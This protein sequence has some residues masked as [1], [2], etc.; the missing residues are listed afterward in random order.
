MKT[1]QRVQGMIAFF[2]MVMG[3][4]GCGHS[5]I[6][7]EA[8][9]QSDQ[10]IMSS[11]F[12][13]AGDFPADVVIPDIEG[14]KSTAFVV[15]TSLP[16]GVIAIDIDADPMKLS[17]KFA[18]FILPDGAGI[19]SRLL[20]SAI[21][22]AFIL[23]SNSIISFNPISGGIYESENILASVNIGS[24][25][26]N[27]DGSEAP[28]TVTPSYPGGIA[29]VGDTLFASTANYTRT[30]TPAVAAPGTVLVFS[31]ENDH[32]LSPNGHILTSHFNPTGLSVRD[33]EDLVITNSGV[34][35]IVDAKGVPKTPSAI[36]IVD[37][38][39]L[40]IKSTIELG[41]VGASFHDVEIT[42]D[43]SRGFIGSSVYGHVYEIDFINTQLLRGFDN[44]IAVNDGSDY[45]SDVVLSVDNALLFAASFE[46]STV[47]PLDL[48]VVP[49]SKGDG[50]VVG[51][52]AGVTETNP[53]GANTGAGPV[54]VRPG[55][56][57]VNYEGEDLF[58]LTGYPGTLVAIQSNAP[59]SSNIS[60]PD[61]SVGDE[62]SASTSQ[63]GQGSAPS[64]VQAPTPPQGSS[65]TSCQGFA[66]AVYSVSYGL[67]AGFGQ[68]SFPNIVLGAPKG[69]GAM[70][71]ST[72]VL[73]LGKNGEIVIDLGNCHV[74][75]GPGTDF[76][77][78]ENPF[79]IGG[80]PSAPYAELGAVAVS[81]NGTSFVEF[82]CNS[83]FYPYNGCAGWHPVY[84]NPGNGISPF[85]IN[86]AGGDAFDLANIGVEDARYIRIRDLKGTS[87]GTAAGFDLDAVAVVNGEIS[88]P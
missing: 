72:D 42:F 79:Y 14:M 76:I 52:P 55:T 2:V 28:D 59:A 18:G 29:R 19:P 49:P 24:G 58:I 60:S 85:D 63:Q 53:S 61:T 44:P 68:G 5:M 39:S 20:V 32:L 75:D 26:K 23:T 66:Q 56:R 11:S 22:Q 9:L 50:F 15:S 65:S 37:P 82:S 48:S 38:K 80:N 47:Y 16:A 7:A 70:G 27:S 1:L 33:K 36:D 73:S 21:D 54:A 87:G 78:F 84:S 62:T 25:Y 69:A 13:L 51:Y 6:S 74:V 30:Q 41:M 34:V 81:R 40:T 45:V 4:V 88:N 17:T 10:S 46:D 83:S 64:Q 43:G 86:T 31:I 35:D 77:V 12:A 67:G 8:Q 71:G 3:M 57:G